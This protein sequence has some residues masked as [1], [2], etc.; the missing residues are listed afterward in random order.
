MP[1]DAASQERLKG[2]WVNNDQFTP[3]K[4]LRSHQATLLPRT[5]W[6]A[7]ATQLLDEAEPG[8][9]NGFCPRGAV[10]LQ[11]LPHPITVNVF[12]PHAR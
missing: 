1:T 6:D 10:S 12:S 8:K 11:P 9:S 4:R 7:S 2:I 5:V 3:N